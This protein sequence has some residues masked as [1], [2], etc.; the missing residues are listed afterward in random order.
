MTDYHFEPERNRTAAYIDGQLV[1]I[2][3]YQLVEGQCRIIHTEVAPSCQGQGI[4]RK[5]VELAARKMSEQGYEIVPVCSYAVR[6]L[7]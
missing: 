5:L 7:G 1:G 3:Q 4:A 6:V 2:C